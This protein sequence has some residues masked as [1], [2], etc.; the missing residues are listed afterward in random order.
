MLRTGARPSRLRQVADAFLRTA[1]LTPEPLTRGDWVYLG[2]L[3]ALTRV[4]IVFVGLLGTALVPELTPARTFVLHPLHPG[5][6]I[7]SRLFDH[8]DAG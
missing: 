4:L 7:W 6:D 1:T 5:D 3:F 2:S 8:F